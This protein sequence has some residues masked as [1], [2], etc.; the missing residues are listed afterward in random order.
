MKTVSCFFVFC[1]L[2]PTGEAVP[3]QP[4]HALCTRTHVYI[5]STTYRSMVPGA[6]VRRICESWTIQTE[7]DGMPRTAHELTT[8]TR[9]RKSVNRERHPTMP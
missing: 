8:D 7:K 2:V 1:A 4:L 9:T 5:Y 6:H 3:L